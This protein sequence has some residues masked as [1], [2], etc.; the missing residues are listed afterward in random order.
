MLSAESGPSLHQEPRLGSDPVGL[1]G[2]THLMS[3]TRGT[4]SVAIGLVDGPIALDHPNLSSANIGEVPDS[5]NGRCSDVTSIG[6][7][8][9]TF[10]AGIFALLVV[11]WHLPSVPDAGFSCGRS[12]RKVAPQRSRRP[13]RRQGNSHG[14]FSM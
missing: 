9:G 12:L 14:R 8:H 11:P 1:V 7:I 4:S 13:G 10:V 6:C 5:S 3:V 2:L